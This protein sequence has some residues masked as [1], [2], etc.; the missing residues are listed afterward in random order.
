MCVSRSIVF[1]RFLLIEL[2][3]RVSSSIKLVVIPVSYVQAM[4][5]LAVKFVVPSD[6]SILSLNIQAMCVCVFFFLEAWV[7]ALLV[8]VF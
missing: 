3:A 1:R 6:Q 2:R 5:E 4:C 7:D 8:C